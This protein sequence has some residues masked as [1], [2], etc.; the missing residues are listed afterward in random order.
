MKKKG[1]KTQAD[2]EW[3]NRTLCSDETCIG[4]IGLNG[5]CRVCG[6]PLGQ[7]NEED[8][9]SGEV[10]LREDTKEDVSQSEVHTKDDIT[11]KI[12]VE[13]AEGIDSSDVDW[14]NRVL[15]SD[16]N[17]IGVIG[18]DGKCKECGKTI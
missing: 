2:I 3:E 18:P 6:K 11:E 12:E 7:V 5:K 17:C 8:A 10:P 16:E 1:S 13:E 15:C 14:E 4:T 9:P